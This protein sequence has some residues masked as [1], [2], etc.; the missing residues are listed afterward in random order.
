MLRN[1]AIIVRQIIYVFLFL[2]LPYYSYKC[3]QLWS[4]LICPSL[5]C[6]AVSEVFVLCLLFVSVLGEKSAHLE[7]PSEAVPSK[8]SH[9]PSPQDQVQK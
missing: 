4:P 6:I 7:F 1:Y 8:Q 9:V 5:E 2:I 3:A